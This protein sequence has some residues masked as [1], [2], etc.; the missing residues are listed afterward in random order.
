[1]PPPGVPALPFDEAAFERALAVPAR[2]ESTASASTPASAAWTTAT[3]SPRSRSCCRRRWR[4]AFRG[5]GVISE[6]H[7]LAVGWGY[8]PHASE[9]AEKVFAGDRKHPLKTGVTTLLAIGVK[10]SEVSTG[11][12][13]NP[14]P[15]HVIHVDAN[16]ATSA[17]C[18]GP[19]CASTPTRA[20]SSA[21]CWPAATRS[22]APPDNALCA[23]I[24][25]LKA[26]AGEGTVQRPAAEVRRR[27]AGAGRSLRRCL[28]DDALLFTD[29]TVTRAPRGRALPRLPAADVL[30]PGGQPGDG[31]DHPGGDRRAAGRITAG[32]SRRSPATAAS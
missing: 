5:K 4:P 12:Y 13:G 8:G 32:R 7:P 26:D 20:C 10:F 14:Q 27:S 24:R 21:G 23:R 19:T 9:V 30:Q 1:M 2:S 31:L 29:V 18:C 17:A 11:Y 15:K 6:S 28:P 3:N 16:P 22:A 25:E